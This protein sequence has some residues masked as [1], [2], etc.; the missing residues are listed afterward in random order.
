[1]IARVLACGL[2]ASFAAVP[3]AAAL[4]S[5]S[6]CVGT[7]DSNSDS[8]GSCGGTVTIEVNVEPGKCR[9]FLSYE[10][11]IPRCGQQKGC[12]PTVKRNCAGMSANTQLNFLRHNRFRRLVHS[13]A[14]DVRR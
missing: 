4:Q 11:W 12:K 6:G 7:G 2:I 13:A 1:M 9:W 8:G 3:N 10:D 14:A 5:C